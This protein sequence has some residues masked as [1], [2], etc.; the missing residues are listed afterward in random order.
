M[1]SAK[2]KAVP[3]WLALAAAVLGAACSCPCHQAG[4]RP[5]ATPAQ[6]AQ[7]PAPAAAP[8]VA[9]AARPPITISIVATNDLHGRIEQLPLFAGYVAN[10]RAARA[11][12]GGGVVVV[13]AGDIFQGTLTSNLTEGA[14][15]VRAFNAIGYTAATLGNHEFDFGPVGPHATVLAPGDDPLGALK[16]RVQEAQF[17]FLTANIRAADDSEFPIAAVKPATMIEVAGIRVGIVGGIT[18]DALGATLVPNVAGLSLT[19]LPGSVAHEARALRAG[20]AQLIVAVVHAGG[21]CKDVHHPEDLTTCDADAEGFKLAWSL[22]PEDVDAIVAG[23]SHAGVAHYVNG[24]PIIE[25]Y[26]N[27]VAFGRIDVSFDRQTGRMLSRHVEPPHPLCAES[28]AKPACTEESYEGAPVRR[29]ERVIAAISA[30]LAR[31]QQEIERPIGVE[32]TTDIA[33]EHKREAPL[34]N[35]IADLMRRAIPGADVAINNGGSLRTPL[36]AGPLR[37]GALFEMFPFDNAF[38]TLRIPAS[39]LASLIATNLQSD[40][41][42]LSLSG[43]R[44]KARCTP[45]GLEVDV[46][47]ENGKRIAP[48]TMLTV[49]TSDFLATGGDGLLASVPL[50]EGAV[51]IHQDKLVR[52]GIVDGFARAPGG[53][54]DGTSPALFDP[55]HPRVQYEGTRPL[56]CSVDTPNNS[57]LR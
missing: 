21:D 37:Y 20:G 34:G 29:D 31:A 49:V 44:A 48:K 26:S 19:P 5:P 56:K 39:T 52:D 35:L 25:S 24:T 36:R 57:L 17:P 40:H 9:A 8:P 54:I 55:K 2:N 41:G 7:A 30:D 33:R 6:A 16:A 51:Q 46:F 45:R 13:D 47:R 15:M 38:A 42:F 27:G 43:A 4:A 1:M 12:D 22:T 23:H 50:P 32:L 53:R 28:L 18:K 10:L 11:R 3:W 14:A